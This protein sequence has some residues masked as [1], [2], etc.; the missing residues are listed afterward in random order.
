MVRALGGPGLVGQRILEDF[1]PRSFPPF[2]GISF[3]RIDLINNFLITRDFFTI[4]D[5]NYSCR[6]VSFTHTSFPR[7]KLINNITI[8]KRNNLKNP[9]DKICSPH[10]IQPLGYQLPHVSPPCGAQQGCVVVGVVPHG[11]YR[12]IDGQPLFNGRGL[13][14]SEPA[15]QIPAGVE[16]NLERKWDPWMIEGCEICRSA[17]VYQVRFLLHFH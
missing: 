6:E 15:I 16:V 11:V 1:C 8:T 5:E 9:T 4:A 10:L 3:S 2:A 17:Y 7:I 14:G 13:P 12:L